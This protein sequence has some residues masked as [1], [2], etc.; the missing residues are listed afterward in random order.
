MKT[1]RKTI[2]AALALLLAGSVIFGLPAV[3]GDEAS[4]WD[5]FRT[6]FVDWDDNAKPGTAKT[7][8]VGVR[9]VEMQDAIG[10]KGYDWEAVKYMEDFQVTVNEEMRFLQEGKLGP[11]Q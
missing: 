9:G 2:V 7:E 6:L 3:A 11:Y 1:R 5:R 10:K 4:Y 8:T